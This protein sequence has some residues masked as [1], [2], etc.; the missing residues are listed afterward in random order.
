MT[1]QHVHVAEGGQAVVGNVST[2]AQGG[3]MRGKDG[4]QP[5]ALAYAPGVEMPRHFEAERETVPSASRAGP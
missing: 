2:P 1:V 3:G 4:E 5:R